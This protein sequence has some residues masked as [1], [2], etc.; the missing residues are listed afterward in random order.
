M[1]LMTKILMMVVVISS[2]P[3]RN[4]QTGKKTLGFLSEIGHVCCLWRAILVSKPFSIVWADVILSISSEEF[5]ETASRR[6]GSNPLTLDF[7]VFMA[8]LGTKPSEKGL[9]VLKRLMSPQNPLV[10]LVQA[11]V[12]VC[13]LRC[14]DHFR[15][16]IDYARSSCLNMSGWISALHA[17]HFPYLRALTLP[18]T[19]PSVRLLPELDAPAL[20]SVRLIGV[21]TNGSRSPS[22]PR[23]HFDQMRAREPQS[24]LYTLFLF[25]K[26][27]VGHLKKIHLDGLTVDTDLE[28]TLPIAPTYER[29]VCSARVRVRTGDVS[30]IDIL[31][32]FIDTSG[33]WDVQTF[34]PEMTP[35]S[36]FLLVTREEA[37]RS[38]ALTIIHSSHMLFLCFSA[39]AEHGALLEDGRSLLDEDFARESR[40]PFVG[41][42]PNNVNLHVQPGCITI[43][44]WAPNRDV[45][46]IL[47][48]WTASIESLGIK[49]LDAC[50]SSSPPGRGV[51]G[52]WEL[53]RTLRPLQIVTFHDD[54]CVENVLKNLSTRPINVVTGAS[55][56]RDGRTYKSA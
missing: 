39:H 45:V 35:S 23:Y 34:M 32:K 10:P 8:A 16:T 25:L 27:F 52:N 26:P 49:R 51:T 42:R 47:R 31:K 4:C 6:A 33:P 56:S 36:D 15:T 55:D 53:L 48:D 29:I 1:E 50:I 2:P 17:K 22:S 9:R 3:G 13:T 38:R 46:P 14:D 7:D 18:L 5:V 41:A 54:S 21:R 20:E 19:E 37:R 43:Q 24:A 40:R 30:T 28:S 11:G 44:S 12:I